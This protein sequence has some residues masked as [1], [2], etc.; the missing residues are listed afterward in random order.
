MERTAAIGRYEDFMLGGRK[1]LLTASTNDKEA[2]AAELESNAYAIIRYIVT[3]LLEWTP[4]EAVE[5]ITPEIAKVM[6]MDV[7]IDK[8]ITVPKDVQKTEDYDYFI[9]RAF[10]REVDYSPTTNLIRLYRKILVGDIK[11]FPRNYFDGVMGLQKAAALLMYVISRN[12]PFDDER[13]GELYERF[14]D[15]SSINRKLKEWKIHDVRRSLYATPL[16]YLHDSLPDDLADSFLFN[17][18]MFMNTYQYYASKKPAKDE[19]AGVRKEE[20]T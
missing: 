19:N 2:A 1:F 15:S 12:I 11:K 10:P 6:R 16:E 3:D 20:N 8:Y 5:C 9:W 13:V 17:Y 7:I 18:Y 14:A 4:Q